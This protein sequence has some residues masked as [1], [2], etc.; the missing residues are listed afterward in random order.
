MYA[1]FRTSGQQFRVANGD[2]I[3]LHAHIGTPGETISFGD[4]LMLKSESDMSIGSPVLV[5]AKVFAEVVEQ[6]RGEKVIIF[7]KRRRKH[8]RRLR[9][10]RQDQTVLKIVGFSLSG[11]QP[12]VVEAPAKAPRA[13]VVAKE[14]KAER[15][16]PAPK[17]KAK[18]KSKE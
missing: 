17:A 3:T 18:S 16:R 11:E 4:V 10:H 7:K 5:T 2:V 9:G 8:Y 15:V 12:P 1:V 14:P 13:P 6:G